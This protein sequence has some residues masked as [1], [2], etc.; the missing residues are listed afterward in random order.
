MKS[1]KVILTIASL[2]L[3]L[4]VVGSL[5]TLNLVD[6][7]ASS[8]EKMFDSKKITNIEINGSN[9]EIE[10][11]STN[12]T[13]I[14][15]ELTGNRTKNL[16]ERL[17]VKVV[18]DTLT[19]QTIEQKKLFNINIFGESLKLTVLLPE[20]VYEALQVDIDNGSLEATQLTIN[21]IR[22]DLDNGQIKMGDILAK[23]VTILAANGK[24]YLDHVEGEIK[25]KTNNGSLFLTTSHVDRHIE[26]AMS[27]GNISIETEKKPTN[28]ILDIKTTNGKATVFGSS[29]WD[30]VSGNGDHVIKLTATNGKI[31]IEN[32]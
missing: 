30:T 2:L 3:L 4:G 8:I 20:K 9:E 6:Q 28:T 18:G 23:S 29:N 14:K 19:I 27:N 1:I 21:E 22:T 16:D 11:V 26:W 13:E 12:D 10:L 17:D 5:L 15:V 7:S 32:K 31:T 25:G 24:V